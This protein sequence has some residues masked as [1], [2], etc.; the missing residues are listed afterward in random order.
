LP[1]SRNYS[2]TERKTRPGGSNMEKCRKEISRKLCSLNQSC[3]FKHNTFT[4][5]IA[6][7][8]R[9]V[10]KC[11]YHSIDRP[12]PFDEVYKVYYRYSTEL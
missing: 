7:F 9:K 4:S 3:L 1:L 8:H 12:G 2:T 11:L 5:M 10:E 6:K